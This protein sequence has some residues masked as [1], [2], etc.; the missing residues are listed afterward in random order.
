MI[1]LRSFQPLF[2]SIFNRVI[3]IWVMRKLCC[4]NCNFLQYF[5]SCSPSFLPLLLFMFWILTLCFQMAVAISI[6]LLRSYFCCLYIF[7]GDP[8][9]MCIFICRIGKDNEGCVITWTIL[10][11]SFIAD[12]LSIPL[13]LEQGWLLTVVILCTFQL[14]ACLHGSAALLY[15]MHWQ[16]IYIPV[17]P[18]HLLDYCW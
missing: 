11:L 13:C 12:T 15:P 17:L 6:W 1:S 16:H 8:W 5:L 7:I 9:D 4:T 14:T 2:L 3:L 10:C 18:P